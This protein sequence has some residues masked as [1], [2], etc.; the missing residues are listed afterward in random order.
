MR[1]T[2]YKISKQLAEAGFEGE[3]NTTKAMLG[4]RD[5]PAFHL[6][7]ILEKLPKNYLLRSDWMECFLCG[8]FHGTRRQKNESL[9]DT[10][11]KLWLK[12]KKEGLV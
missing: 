5:Y 12:L 4:T 6:E 7:T 11:A 1:T 2:N 9:A 8:D 3:T 10:A